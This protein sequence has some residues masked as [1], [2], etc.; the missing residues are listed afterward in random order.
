MSKTKKEI[1]KFKSYIISNPSHPRME[2]TIQL[3]RI[4]VTNEEMKIDFGYQAGEFIDGGWIDIKKETFIRVKESESKIV[5]MKNESPTKYLLKRATN[6][7][8]GPEKHHFNSTI[9]WRYFSL[10]FPKLPEGTLC[11]DLIEKEFGDHNH[12]NFFSIR[13]DEEGKKTYIY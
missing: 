10:F 4:I 6:V 3:L 13:L 7:P 2:D 11:F 8:Y 5:A 9:E 1:S 12:F